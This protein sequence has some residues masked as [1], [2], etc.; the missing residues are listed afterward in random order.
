MI[1]GAHVILYSKDSEADREFIRDG[2]GFNHVDVGGGWLLFAT[3]PAELAVPPGPKNDVHEL[4]LM[5]DDVKGLIKELAGKGV[6][7]AAVQEERWGSL[8]RLTL[9]SGSK[10]G[11]YQPKHPSPKYRAPAAKKKKATRPRR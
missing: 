1:T 11:V 8:T 7:C 5:T 3:P 10:L 4:Y 6:A 9:P 2:L